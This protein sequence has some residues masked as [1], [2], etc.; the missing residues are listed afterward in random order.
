MKDNFIELD[1]ENLPNFYKKSNVYISAI[2]RKD[3]KILIPKE[4]YLSHDNINKMK[5]F[6]KM[7]NV[8]SYI[9]SSELPES[10]ISFIRKGRNYLFNFFK[11]IN[12]NYS[13]LS[14]I[15]EI[16]KI[17]LFDENTGNVIISDCNL[18][19]LSNENDINRHVIDIISDWNL[20][21]FSNENIQKYQLYNINIPFIESD[22][23]FYKME[24]NIPEWLKNI[25]NSKIRYFLEKSSINKN[26]TEIIPL[27]FYF[28]NI[29]VPETNEDVLLLVKIS[30]CFKFDLSQIYFE[31][32][33]NKKSIFQFQYD[34]DICTLL[35]CRYMSEHIKILSID[36]KFLD[37]TIGIFSSKYYFTILNNLYMIP[38]FKINIDN[39][40]NFKLFLIDLVNRLKN[41]NIYEINQNIIIEYFENDIVCLSVRLEYIENKMI[42]KFKKFDKTF[43]IE[44]NGYSKFKII[45]VLDIVI[46]DLHQ[47][48]YLSNDE[49]DY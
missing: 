6:K 19:N 3:T 10:F 28:Y 11:T 26:D 36:G 31:T 5:N 44:Y 29:F 8:L 34:E 15:I 33:F 16:V 25:N 30:N 38:Y 49:Y 4:H 27:F 23:K 24:I 37:M 42:L 14:I 46:E 47:W 17:L 41:V 43:E 22:M 2:A 40:D 13:N 1:I 18:I 35:K 7:F 32:F 39:P 48:K 9:G 21:N 20:I 12:K 45:E